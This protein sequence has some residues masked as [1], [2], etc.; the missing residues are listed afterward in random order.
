MNNLIYKV[1]FSRSRGTLMVVNEASSSVQNNP[2]TKSGK[3]IVRKALIGAVLS[4]LACAVMAAQGALLESGDAGAGGSGATEPTSVIKTSDDLAAYLKQ[5]GPTISGK[6]NSSYGAL[7]FS[8]YPSKSQ[9]ST[10]DLQ[11][12]TFENNKASKDKAGF[13]GAISLVSSSTVTASDVTFT[14]NSATVN[15]GAV[16]VDGGSNFTGNGL[17]FS[18]NSAGSNGGA[19]QATGGKVSITNSLFDS[20]KA[21]AGGAVTLQHSVSGSFVDTIFTNNESNGW[22]GAVRLFGSSNATFKVSDGKNLLYVGNHS[23][24]EDV[25][26]KWYEGFTGGFLLSTASTA[27]FDIGANASLTIGNPGETAHNVDSIVS[28]KSSDNGG[29]SGSTINKTGAGTLTVNGSTEAYRGTFNV[30]AGHVNLAG[31]YGSYDISIQ[32]ALNSTSHK[33]SK[34]TI[35]TASINVSGGASVSMGNAT[36]DHQVLEEAQQAGQGTLPNGGLSISVAAG[37]VFEGQNVT[38]QKRI[39]TQTYFAKGTD[40]TKPQTYDT[41]GGYLN[42]SNNGDVSFRNVSLNDKSTLVINGSGLT[43]VQ[44]LSIASGST[45]NLSGSSTGGVL[46]V[47][48]KVDYASGAT[49]TLGNGTLETGYDNLFTKG[50]DGKWTLSS[51]GTAVK[52]SGISGTIIETSYT[53][54]YTLDDLKKANGVFGVSSGENKFFFAYGSLQASGGGN[55]NISDLVTNGGNFGHSTVTVSGSD[56]AASVTLTSSDLSVGALEV[57]NT[58]TSLTINNSGGSN[59]GTLTLVGGQDGKL[60]AGSTGLASVSVTGT[61]NLGSQIDQNIDANVETLSVGT[62]NVAGNVDAK[63]VS[64]TTSGNVTGDL[65]VTSLSAGTGGVT[66]ADGGSLILKGGA[67]SVAKAAVPDIVSGAVTVNGVLTTN[68]GASNALLAQYGSEGLTGAA[69]IDRQVTFGD[70]ASLKIGTDAGFRSARSVQPLAV[71]GT[72]TIASGA[73]AVIDAAGFIQPAKATDPS[74]TVLATQA[75]NSVFGSTTTVTNN[76]TIVLTNVN[77]TGE[78]Q[79]GADGSKLTNSAGTGGAQGTVEMESM[80]LSAKASSG[81]ISVTYNNVLGKDS[82]LDKRLADKFAAGLSAKE[83][84]IL[85]AIGTNADFF[86]TPTTRATATMTDAGKAALVQATG[87]NVT[88]GVFNAAYDANAQVTDAIIRHQTEPKAMNNGMWADVFYA[89]N[90]AKTIYGTSGYK[91]S[92]YGGMIGY[93]H[94]FIC[95]ANAGVAL[96]IGT[97]DTKSK[98]AQL[99]TTLDSDFYGVSVYASKDLANVNVKA[100]LGYMK[101]SNS[102]TGLGDASDASTFTVGLRGDVPV[103]QTDVFALVPHIGLRY[104]NIDTDAVAFNDAKKMNVFETPIGVKF[105]GFVDAGQWKLR[106]MFDFTIVPQL[107][108]K[109]V[110]TFSSNDV[111]VLSTSLYNSTLGVGADIGQFSMRLDATYGF[112]NE[113]RNNTQVNLQGVYRF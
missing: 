23:G 83:G 3:K 24:T 112:G 31:T 39:Y 103:V 16:N 87:G 42:I 97:G 65:S 76:G 22:G 70:G 73:V 82:A 11:G 45:V 93:D 75:D 79:V 92:I 32:G 19:L 52:G 66:V 34:D 72:V 8:G 80:F 107:G 102:L 95:G 111:N 60:F 33:V 12:L 41:Q 54:T 40:S 69:Y 108:D 51:F 21:N 43:Q 36:V 98:N 29:N 37:G 6:D 74:P 62:L 94:T 84:E 46:A 77:K 10:S 63:Q 85:N 57:A 91:S 58:A 4:S 81:S 18:G 99:A 26:Y 7:Q 55:A 106:P 1:V 67:Q 14:S 56:A 105:M 59:T 48:G 78:I 104:T 113:D 68:E 50:T 47:T 88:T 2:G 9:A 64:V 110:D 61:L 53:G 100:D 96:A 27:T 35:Q 89:Q 13:G 71:A 38:L 28:T 90:E 25:A 101:F 49:F 44:S 109:S 86:T 17:T 20:N 30:Q 15:G 5:Y